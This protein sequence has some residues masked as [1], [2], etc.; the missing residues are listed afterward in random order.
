MV[1]W[2]EGSLFI[3]LLKLLIYLFLW[4]SMLY[5]LPIKSSERYWGVK[6][7]HYTSHSCNHC[8][9][10]D[11]NYVLP[12]VPAHT[13]LSM[14][15]EQS[16]PVLH[17]HFV[18]CF[19]ILLSVLHCLLFFRLDLKTQ[20]KHTYLTNHTPLFMAQ[21]HHCLHKA[22]LVFYYIFFIFCTHF[23]SPPPF[24]CFQ[25]MSSGKCL[26]LKIYS[27]F[28]YLCVWNKWHESITA[29]INQ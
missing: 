27:C 9:D 13:S 10:F 4:L 20:N 25:Y 5:V 12:K 6:Y 23:Y 18:A 26:Y 22:P 3:R 19:F 24:Y 8:W 2:T 14:C 29:H 21:Y 17:T 28:A 7:Y 1:L 11:V 16:K 15:I